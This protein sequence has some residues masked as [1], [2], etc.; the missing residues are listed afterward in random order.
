M[1]QEQADHVL[2]VDGEDQLVG[3][4]TR[5]DLLRIREHQ[6]AAEQRQDGHWALRAR[7][8]VSEG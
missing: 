8:R 1:L 2:V 3:I 4:C 5:T 7:L 6:L